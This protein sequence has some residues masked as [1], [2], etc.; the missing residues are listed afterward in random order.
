MTSRQC[1]KTRSVTL[2]EEYKKMA[3]EQSKE[4]E[5]IKTLIRG[6]KQLTKEQ[7]ECIKNLTSELKIQ[8]NRYEDLK[9]DYTQLKNDHKLVNTCWLLIG[10][11]VGI[12]TGVML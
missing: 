12:I 8:L 3:L 11:M 2:K 9:Q 1:I 6:Q 10:L 5:E 7:A 4:L